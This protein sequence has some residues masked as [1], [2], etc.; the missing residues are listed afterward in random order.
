MQRAR[1]SYNGDINKVSSS[2]P[3]P[4][5]DSSSPLAPTTP[6]RVSPIDQQITY[7]V[8][9][10][11]TKNEKE[12]RAKEKTVTGRGGK[13]VRKERKVETRGTN[14]RWER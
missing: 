3:L 1:V 14:L 10:L 2:P 7:L 9:L 12:G 11:Y 6:Q 4:L 8:C 5:L 13:K